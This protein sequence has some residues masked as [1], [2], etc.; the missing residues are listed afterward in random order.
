MMADLKVI[1]LFLLWKVQLSL[2][3]HREAL[4]KKHHTTGSQNVPDFCVRRCSPSAVD[5]QVAVVRVSGN[6][7]KCKAFGI[8]R[9]LD[10]I[11]DDGHVYLTKQK[12]I[13]KFI[14][15]T[16]NLA[17]TTSIP[18]TMSQTQVTL[19]VTGPEELIWM[20]V[21]FDNNNDSVPLSAAL[22]FDE[23]MVYLH[24]M[25]NG[26]W[27]QFREAIPFNGSIPKYSRISTNVD[28]T[29]LFMLSIGDVAVK[30]GIKHPNVSILMATKLWILCHPSCNLKE[31]KFSKQ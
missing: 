9:L 4:L 14:P 19:T 24:V 16:T 11:P 29:G 3:D 5:L 12:N 27:G 31:I 6:P 13:H 23:N 15:D 22:M 17:F 1:F 18:M 10:G 28:Q 7:C 20:M 21:Q 30:E 2:A 8:D 25:D 26:H